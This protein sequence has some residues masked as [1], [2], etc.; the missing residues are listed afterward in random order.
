MTEESIVSV[1]KPAMRSTQLPDWTSAKWVGALDLPASLA[2]SIELVDSSGYRKAR[3]LVRHRLRPVAF[4]DVDVIKNIVD[5]VRLAEIVSRYNHG[6]QSD[7]AGPRTDDLPFIT[8]VMCT[9]NRT[10]SLAD[11]LSSVLACDYPRFEVIV[12][13]NASI[14]DAT[15]QYVAQLRDPRVR[16]LAEPVP[17][18][19]VAR[20]AGILAAR[21][22]VV[23]FTDDD[24]VVDPMWLRWFG[25][26]IQTT[27]KVG[28]VTGLVPGGEF[29]TPAQCW[30]DNQM[31]WSKNLTKEVFDITRPPVGDRLFP[32]HVGLYGAGASFAMPRSVLTELGGFDEAL[33]AGSPTGAC[34]DNDMFL[35]VLAAGHVL[36]YEPAAVVWHRHRADMAGLVTQVRSYGLGLGAWLTKVACDRSL[37]PM[38]FRKLWPAIR[39]IHGLTVPAHVN[40]FDMP[41]NLRRIQIMSTLRGPLAYAR[42]RRQGRR[43]NPLTCVSDGRHRA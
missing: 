23:A 34:E 5:G 27:P 33:G 11:A 6:Y 12:V 32:F 4:V 13:D 7:V 30:F 36:I 31:N 22:D 37:S 35:R 14:N 10:A 3:L 16:A 20:N 2:P 42:S 9:R 8:V 39:H 38:A 26:A 19:S 17:G 18:L 25:H 43:A 15:A 29:R 1:L 24:V 40:N 21:G 28:C 41:S